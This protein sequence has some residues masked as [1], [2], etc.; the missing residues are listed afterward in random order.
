MKPEQRQATIDKNMA[1]RK[2]FNERM[3]ELVKKRDQ[4]V[5]DQR[6]N[7]LAKPADSF[8]RA[9]ADTLRAQIKR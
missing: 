3:A 8:D 6:K 5:I 2:S 4:Y 9:V 1:E 7:G